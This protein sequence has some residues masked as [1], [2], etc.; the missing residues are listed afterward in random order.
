MQAFGLSLLAFVGFLILTI[1]VFRIVDI[2]RTMHALV[3]TFVVVLAASI[4]YATA[5]LRGVDFLAFFSVY[6]CLFLIFVQVFS[7]F[8]KSISL[9]LV[10][11]IRSRQG[12]RASLEWVYGE[13]I[14]AGSYRRRLEILEASG[15]ISRHAETIA[16]TPAGHRTAERLI[17]AQKFLGIEK[18]G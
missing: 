10:L 1:A 15:L 11:D 13:C 18:S 16:L 8:Y 6:V 4:A 14:L 12:D 7:I 5:F 17:A 3:A 9:R 2:K